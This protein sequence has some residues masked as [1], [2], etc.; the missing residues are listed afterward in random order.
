MFFKVTDHAAAVE[1]G[2]AVL[3]G[4]AALQ[5]AG[6]PLPLHGCGNVRLL[7][8]RP[9]QGWDQASKYWLITLL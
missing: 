8:L 9:D 5:H 4:A 3:R 1:R 7:Q 2:G 6:A